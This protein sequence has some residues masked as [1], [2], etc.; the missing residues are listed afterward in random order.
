MEA[1]GLLRTPRVLDGAQGPEVVV[2]GRRALCLC[3]NNY[4]GFAGHPALADAVAETVQRVGF[5]AC[6]S[7][8]INGTM[9]IHDELETRIAGFVGQER[10]LFFPTGYTAN[11]GAVQALSG[12]RTL[13]LSDALNHASLIDGCRLGRADVRVYR[14]A[15]AEHVE[16]LLR[17]TGDRYDLK[18]VVTESLFSMDGDLAPLAAL[19]GLCDRYEAALFVDDAHALGVLGHQGAGACAAA[20][21]KPDVITGTFGKAFGCSGAFVAGSKVLLAWMANRAR[22]HV[23]STAPSPALAAAALA[24]FTLVERADDRRVTLQRHARA[25]REGLVSAGYQL[26]PS[27]AHIIPVLLG[28][29]ERATELSGMLLDRGV[30]VH[31]IRPPTVAPGTSRLRVT[32]MATHTSEQMAEAI[33]VF[34]ELGGVV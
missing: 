15:D 27:E 6:G 12:P 33:A 25:L 24:A 18:L 14:H 34:R 19:R 26:A 30:F 3:S 5:G 16:A 1:Q 8:L 7:R 11:L 23:F 10:A 2:D 31:G 32:P 22:S 4:L 17:D 13:V 9:R 28:S 29:A 20:G 21:V